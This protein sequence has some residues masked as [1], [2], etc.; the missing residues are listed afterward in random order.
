MQRQEVLLK[1][2]AVECMNLQIRTNHKRKSFIVWICSFI[3]AFVPI[4]AQLAPPPP[5][6][7]KPS[8]SLSPAVIMGKGTFG[9][10]L[11][12]TLTLSNNTGA[13]LGFELLAQD[14]IVKDGKRVYVPAGELP[15]SIAATAVFS[16]KKILVKAHTS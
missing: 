16:P 9:Q 7:D 5:P 10:G 2:F 15:D 1:E 12:Q 6:P 13:D 14:M 8:I 4:H 11:T 3:S